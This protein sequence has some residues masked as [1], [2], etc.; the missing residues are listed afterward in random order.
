MTQMAY[1]RQLR[2]SHLEILDNLR[3]KNSEKE[4]ENKDNYNGIEIENKRDV[5]IPQPDLTNLGMHGAI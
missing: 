2:A 5:R 4:S 3:K 1:R